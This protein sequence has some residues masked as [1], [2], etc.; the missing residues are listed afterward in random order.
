MPA[1]CE[2]GFHP[3][4][5]YLYVSFPSPYDCLVRAGLVLTGS[6]W[7]VRRDANSHNLSLGADRL[8]ARKFIPRVASLH[9]PY[10]EVALTTLACRTWLCVHPPPSLKRVRESRDTLVC[11]SPCDVD[12]YQCAFVWCCVC[13]SVCVCAHVCLMEGWRENAG[14][15][16]SA[17]PYSLWRIQGHSFMFCQPSVDQFP[18]KVLLNSAVIPIPVSR[19]LPHCFSCVLSIPLVFP[20]ICCSVSNMSC[21]CQSGPVRLSND[22]S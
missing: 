15:G 4:H 3:L 14:E 22:T 2:R 11:V 16:E 9:L 19:F 5:I 1:A 20:L 17:N 10:F 18:I 6:W 13:A 8:V 12:S 7:G 21:Q